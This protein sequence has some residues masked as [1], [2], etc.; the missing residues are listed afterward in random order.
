MQNI[1]REHPEYVARKAM[2]KQYQDLYAGGEQLR[3]NASEYL[4]RRHKEPDEVYRGAAEPGVLRELHR[5]DHRLVR[6]DADAARADDAVR[7]QRRRRRRRS[8]TC[9][10]TIAI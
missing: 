3:L 4:V 2:W 7:R 10:R 6:G 5:V 1:N 8:T 9:W